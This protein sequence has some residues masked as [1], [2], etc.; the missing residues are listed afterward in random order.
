M[1]I[2]I[3]IHANYYYYLIYGGQILM[4]LQ[5]TSLS[6]GIQYLYTT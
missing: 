1:Q 5:K 6:Q 2:I 4:N 3:I